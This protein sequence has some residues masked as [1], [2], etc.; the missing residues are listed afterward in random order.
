MQNSPTTALLF[1]VLAA[2]LPAAAVSEA[3]SMPRLVQKDG[4][5]AL[6]VDGAP[7]LMLGVQAGNS[8][9]WPAMLPKVWPA[10]DFVHANTLEIPIYWE[11]FEPQPGVFDPS[12]VDTLIKQAREHHVRLVL[13]W[14]GTWK[15][16]SAHYMPLW[17]KR[18]AENY[19]KVIGKDGRRVDSPSP[20]AAAP[21][22]AD[23]RAFRALMH[24]LKAVDHN[25]TVIMVQV[26]N[27]PGTWNSVR[28]YSPAAEK[29]FA[30]PV[31]AELLRALGKSVPA[32]AGWAA[33]FGSDAAEYFHAWSVARYIGQVAAAGKAE[34]P[35]PLYVN[36]ALRD[37]LSNPPANTYES[38][39]P[40]DNVLSI[41]KAAAPA[42]D[43]LAPDIYLN[44]GPRYQKV[45]ELY[46]RPDNPLFVPETSSAANISRYC[47]A[48]LGRGAIGWAPFGVDYTN[49]AAAPI[50]APWLTEE[51]LTHLALN[52]RLLG[53]M[54]REVARLNF[55]GRLQTAV[56]EKDAPVQTL[57]FGK[58]RASV[59]FG[60]PGW[61]FGKE[62]KGNPE[63]VGRVLVAQTGENEFLVAGYFC[64]VDFQLSD[65]ASGGQREYL[66]VEEG[67]YENGVFQPVR[68][69]NGDQTDWGL[70]FSSVPQILRV[71]L[72]T[73]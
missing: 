33:V 70:N 42:I 6:M 63:P 44:D 58:W 48:A 7:Y 25:H 20:H 39:G 46:S 35:L 45:L 41:W 19:P 14:F 17:M 72:G 55:E 12:M 73:Y 69:W 52:F 27:E 26:E 59:G 10:V 23:T 43:V 49:Y 18:D 4:R 15:N 9:D 29:L 50:G 21:L 1:A 22:E 54:M 28:D 40:T 16:G 71:Q 56:E 3:D 57:A 32:G 60:V 24:H 36:A 2:A 65:P 11:Q 61:G 47:F 67:G 53:P 66:H 37:P 31:P 64:R 34:Y 38:G 5:H 51:K 68:I 8:S 30:A 13:L 62:P